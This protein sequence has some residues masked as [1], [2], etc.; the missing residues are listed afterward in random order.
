MVGGLV[1]QQDVRFLKQQAAQRHTPTLAAAEVLHWLVLVG[2]AQGIHGAFQ[3]AVE[4]P[5]IVLVKQFGQLALALAQLVEVCIGLGKGIVH[6][7]VLLQ[8][9][10]NRLH[11]LLHHLFYR[12]AVVQL[13]LLFQIT[14]AVA[15]RE[16]HLALVVLVNTG[17]D[18]QQ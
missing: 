17:N 10:H 15:R 9:I 7:L 4:V 6:L 12:L 16:D 3:P 2:A 14:H 11:S 13:G 18:F 8:C 5:G 1:K